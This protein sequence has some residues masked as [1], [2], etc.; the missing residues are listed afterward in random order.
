MTYDE[1]YKAIKQ[2]KQTFQNRKMEVF[3]FDSFSVLKNKNLEILVDHDIADDVCNRMWCEDS[4]GYA[5]ANIGRSVIRLHDYVMAKTHRSKPHGCFVDHINQDK[6]DNRRT[7]LRFVTPTENSRN[8]PIRANN[9]SGITGVS[10]TKYGSYRAYV[11]IR[12]KQINLGHYQT[13]EEAASARLEA[14]ERLG[15]KTRSGTVREKLSTIL[16]ME[17]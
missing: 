11:T 5:V 16:T 6:H 13:I 9:T 1:I 15:F 8:V 2:P 4:G 10:K 17:E 3:Q 12:Q 14:E 7:N